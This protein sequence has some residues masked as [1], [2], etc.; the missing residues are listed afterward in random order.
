MYE[1]IQL[2]KMFVRIIIEEIIKEIIRKKKLMIF[3]KL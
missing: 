3:K 2:E 1:N